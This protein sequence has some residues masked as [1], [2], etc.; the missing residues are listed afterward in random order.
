MTTRLFIE[1]R[2]ITS[3]R[4]LRELVN[5]IDS[6]TSSTGRQLIA[7]ACDGVIGRWLKEDPEAIRSGITLNAERLRQEG[8]VKRWLIMKKALTGI[9]EEQSFDYSDL[10]E[11]VSCPNKD[12]LI[13]LSEGKPVT[14]VFEL[15]SK[16]RIDEKVTLE[17]F[18]VIQQMDMNKDEVQTLRF[19]ID[20]KRL[21]KDTTVSL[22]V[23]GT[24]ETLWSLPFKYNYSELFE[25]IEPE[26]EQLVELFDGD[27]VTLLFQIRCKC[28]KEEH[29]SLK[30]LDVT[31]T[32][33]MRN[34]RSQVL[35]FYVL[36]R[37]FDYGS[38]ISLVI[39]Y[40]GDILWSKPVSKDIF[41]KV[42]DVEF[43]MVYVKGDTFWMGAQRLSVDD[44]NYD[45]R[46]SGNEN[47]IHKVTLSDY[48]IGETVV[49]QALWKSVMNSN[50]PFISGD[51][52]P[53]V[54]VKYKGG[55]DSV[56]TFINKLNRKLEDRLHGEFIFALPTEAQWEY[57]A[58]GG[59][60]RQNYRY[61]GGKN[62]DEVGWYVGNSGNRV[63][64]VKEKEKKKANELGIYDM[65]GNV[66]E[67]CQDRIGDYNSSLQ[68]NPRGKSSGSEC[69][70]RG[71]SWNESADCCRV[72][73][74]NSCRI[75]TSDHDIGFR[76]VL[77]HT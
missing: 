14:L 2:Y 33:D 24:G 51:D 48:Y 16:S 3:L 6:P 25:I 40:N 15:R 64:P 18:D 73:Y 53:V 47:P 60:M 13:K 7:S 54:N 12:E 34:P 55:K 38:S 42:G 17:V 69:V 11:I 31:E 8:D 21:Y 23:K 71:G 50:P 45:T 28:T 32:L 22:S 43:K 39:D 75:D 76:L 10:I 52:F 26:N 27:S 35:Q 4:E 63:H 36:P 67:W 19:V 62:L 57:A 30:L 61:S 74:R 1:D 58:R 49:T 72:A 29:I 41:F 56:P 46:A 77:I 68:I 44:P 37:Q 66:W 5:S 59:V 20:H 65:S 70:L 9:S